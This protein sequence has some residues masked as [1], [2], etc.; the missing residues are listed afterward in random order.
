MSFDAVG[1]RLLGRVV[2]LTGSSVSTVEEAFSGFV[3]GLRLRLLEDPVANKLENDNVR[4]IVNKSTEDEEDESN[5]LQERPFAPL[6]S[7]SDA[8]VSEDNGCNPDEDGTARVDEGTMDGAERLGDRETEKVET[9]DR[10]NVGNDEAQQAGCLANLNK[11]INDI[12]VRTNV[13]TRQEVAEGQ[14]EKTHDESSERSFHTND[15]EGGVMARFQEELLNDHLDG[16]K[17]LTSQNEDQTEREKVLR[18]VIGAFRFSGVRQ[19]DSRS[20]ASQTSSHGQHTDP[21]VHA[22]LLLEEDDTQ[23][24]RK[25]DRSTAQHLPGRLWVS[26]AF[27]SDYDIG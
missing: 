25:D 5:D 16:S 2:E 10:E 20:D 22:K 13:V 27:L 3:V 1:I 18:R 11:G 8:Q 7:G 19:Q 12:L 24:T 6:L 21:M 9:G 17:D 14:D 26:N 4:S 15:V 23:N